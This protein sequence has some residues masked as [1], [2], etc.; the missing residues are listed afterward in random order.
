MSDLPVI[1][2][3]DLRV[4][5]AAAA[6]DD[7]S[8]RVRCPDCQAM[9]RD[10]PR[11]EALHGPQETL[12]PD[13]M[14]PDT[15]ALRAL[16]DAAT[17]GPRHVDARYYVWTDD[18]P[19]VDGVEVA[20]FIEAADA[21][22]CAALDPDTVRALCDAA[23]EVE[24]L[25]ERNAAL[26]ARID[27]AFLA[28]IGDLT[29]EWDASRTARTALVADLRALHRPYRSPIHVPLWCAGCNLEHPCPTTERLDRH[30]PEEIS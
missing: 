29:A 2:L 26:E 10:L 24:R 4:S 19:D 9:T 28:S 7:A 8:R 1:D 22:L 30:A 6:A 11:H 15:A 3:A 23:D 21:G 25:R 13:R 14:T 18:T 5:L 27:P 12:M 17:Q 16:A 20:P